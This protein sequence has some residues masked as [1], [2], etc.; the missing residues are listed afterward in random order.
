MVTDKFDV[1]K[2]GP[3]APGEVLLF[4]LPEDFTD[5]EYQALVHGV[6]KLQATTLAGVPVLMLPH[7]MEVGALSP[8]QRARVLAVLLKCEC[9]KG[10]IAAC[11]VCE[12]D[13]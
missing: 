12:N 7:D 2:L 11:P 3:F 4:R 10:K 8:E 9:G 5:N 1:T 13:E 6:R